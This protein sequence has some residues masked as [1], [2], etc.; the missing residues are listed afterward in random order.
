[1]FWYKASDHPPFRLCDQALWADNRPFH[2]TMLSTDQYNPDA[3]KKKATPS[4]WV[5]KT[6][7]PK[8]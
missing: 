8:H 7:G 3:L 4:V 1:V 6:E 2:S 5:K